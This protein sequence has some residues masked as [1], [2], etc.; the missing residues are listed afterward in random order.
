M[1]EALM[2]SLYL[3]LGLSTVLAGCGKQKIDETYAANLVKTSLGVEGDVTAQ[4]LR[5]GLSSAQVFLV[6]TKVKKYV[7]RFVHK[8]QEKAERELCCL[9]IA[10]DNGYG[11]HV[12]FADPKQAVV[13]MEYLSGQE[14]TLQDRQSEDF[15]K[16]LGRLLHK[17]HQGH[18]CQENKDWFATIRA[19]VE[20]IKATGAQGIP[21]DAVESLVAAIKKSVLPYQT[22]T[23]CHNDLNPG[24]LIFL[25]N[26]LKAI[27]Y[28]T[29][30]QNDPYF[31][32][33]TVAMFY[34]YNPAHEKVLLATYLD[35]Q[36]SV[37]EQAR[38]YMMR[39]IAW[40]NYAL[41]FLRMIPEK[42]HLYGSLQV[43]TY[44]GL[45]KEMFEGKID[46]ENP[47][48]KLKYAKVLINHVIA[49][50]GTQ[51]FRDAVKAL[52]A[53]PSGDGAGALQSLH[54]IVLD[55]L[56]DSVL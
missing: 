55:L 51:E 11:P 8:S 14:I 19:N 15:Y 41:L 9:Q 35:R 27:D 5:G 2:K 47:D 12:Y 53:K 20:K 43:P 38:L 48:H 39:Q 6:A 13:I 16:A 45:L 50:A 21:L 28:E 7:V 52:E 22:V 40:L 56:Q 36:P 17:M 3:L 32:V 1:K 10:S 54:R 31:D 30:G 33:A 4:V 23:L 37:Q 18:G 49:N 25:G 34:C 46:F 29:C 26:E 24:N 42:V 44:Q